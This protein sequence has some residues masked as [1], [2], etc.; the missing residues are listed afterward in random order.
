M[1]NY[2]KLLDA[3]NIEDV[4]LEKFLNSFATKIEDKW[5]D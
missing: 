5:I 4:Y 1:K 3:N 2:Q